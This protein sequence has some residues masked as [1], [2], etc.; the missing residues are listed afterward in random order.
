VKLEGIVNGESGMNLEGYV[1][2][3]KSQ[4]YCD[5]GNTLTNTQDNE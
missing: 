5:M 2:K 1:S 4:N 3:Y